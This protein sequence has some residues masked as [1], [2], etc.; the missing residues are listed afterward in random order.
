[1]FSENSGSEHF[2]VRPTL[3]VEKHLNKITVF[4]YNL[5]TLKIPHY[6][7]FYLF[8]L[9]TV[10]RIIFFSKNQFRLRLN[11]RHENIL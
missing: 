7:S 6:L 5:N 3:I 9:L 11:D 4:N 2:G 1:M 8:S 10:A